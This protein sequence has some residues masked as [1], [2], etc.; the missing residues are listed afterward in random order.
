MIEESKKETFLQE[1]T[2]DDKYQLSSDSDDGKDESN[3]LAYPLT[4][5]SIIEAN[6]WDV[7]SDSDDDIEKAKCL[8]HPEIVEQLSPNPGL[9]PMSLFK[10]FSNVSKEPS[11]INDL[12]QHVESKSNKK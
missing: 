6:S 1:I 8:I 5:R 12:N 10:N 11:Q 3:T 4:K 2:D 9:N 7:S